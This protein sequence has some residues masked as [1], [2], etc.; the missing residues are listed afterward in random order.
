MYYAHEEQRI[1]KKVRQI[2]YQRT[3]ELLEE[4]ALA[5]LKDAMGLDKRYHDVTGNALTSTVI[6][7]YHKG[8]LV[9]AFQ[10]SDSAED[11]TMKTLR[12]GQSYPLTEYY[13]GTDAWF[14]EEGNPIKPYV[15]EE[16]R[17]GQWGPTLSKWYIHRLH[18]KAKNT[19]SIVV[20]I[21]VSY[22]QS[23][24]R[25]VA[26]MQGV[27]DDIGYHAREFATTRGNLSGV[28]VRLKEDGPVLGGLFD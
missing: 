10:A 12:A 1:I 19:W 14:D 16:G 3:L 23:N 18:T 15:G 22:A 28:N 27:F 5:A 9:K 13:D 20:A 24:E 8:R 11:P 2:T 17:G 21:P 26:T 4:T 25:I 6:G 7:I